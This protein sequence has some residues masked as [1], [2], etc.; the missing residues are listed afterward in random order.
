LL[1]AAPTLG[2]LR[3]AAD[4]HPSDIPAKMPSTEIDLEVLI[5][6]VGNDPKILSAMLDDF[7]SSV[8][9]QYDRICAAVA[10]GDAVDFAR[11]AHSI[12]GAAWY[13]GATSLAQI[14]DQLERRVKEDARLEE[15]G[16]DLSMLEA[17]IVRLPVEIA[18]A[19]RQPA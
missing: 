11:Q 5:Q 10:A 8:T 7:Q 4:P 14:C 12:K 9:A 6:L 16:N 1:S 3:I 19:L 13:A 17:A 15:L 2:A 18:N